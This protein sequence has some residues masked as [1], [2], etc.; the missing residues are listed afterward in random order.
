ME[1]SSLIFSCQRLCYNFSAWSIEEPWGS[2]A[3]WAKL[4]WQVL[5]LRAAKFSFASH[6]LSDTFKCLRVPNVGDIL[7]LPWAPV[8]PCAPCLCLAPQQSALL[9]QVGWSRG[10]EAEAGVPWIGAHLPVLSPSRVCRR[11]AGNLALL[12]KP[13]LVPQ[14]VLLQSRARL[15]VSYLTPC[16]RSGNWLKLAWAILCI[17]TH[18]LCTGLPCLPT[19]GRLVKLEGQQ[20]NERSIKTVL[21]G[22][23]SPS[24]SSRRRQCHWA[25]L[26]AIF[27][28]LCLP[29]LLC[30]GT[31]STLLVLPGQEEKKTKPKTSCSGWWTRIQVQKRK[32]WTKK[33]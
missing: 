17:G 1:C 6:H 7:V 16:I 12:G 33:G 27:S 8:V 11:R 19:A 4:V 20:R 22:N 32:A 5:L 10:D 21:L 28:M 26:L 29:V 24:G 31:L 15:S 13:V 23:G 9:T 3:V 25:G 30:S 2:S 14:G 18:C